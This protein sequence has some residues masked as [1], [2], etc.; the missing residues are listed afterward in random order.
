MRARFGS[1]G[2]AP[3]IGND[4]MKLNLALTQ[5]YF[6]C[7]RSSLT[8]EEAPV[9]S[10][11]AGLKQRVSL[12]RLRHQADTMG[13]AWDSRAPW[14]MK[15]KAHLLQLLTKDGI[16]GATAVSYG[17][18]A[19][20]IPN[21]PSDW[22]PFDAFLSNPSQTGGM[23]F[24]MKDHER[25]YLDAYK[26]HSIIH[27]DRAS[28]IEA[29][30]DDFAMQVDAANGDH[31]NAKKTEITKTP[32]NQTYES[33]HAWDILYKTVSI[34]KEAGN[35]A[36]RGSQPFLAARRYD[37]AINYCSIAYLE[38]QVGNVDFLAEHQVAISD[39]DGYECRWNPLLKLLIQIRLNLSM[40]F[41]K[42]EMKDVK[43]AKNQANFSLRE[44]KP[45][46]TKKGVVLT[47]KKLDK[48]RT[49]EPHTTYTESK[50]LQSKA[51]FRLGSAQML[52]G[53]FDDAI[54]CFE[55]SVKSTKAMGD[56][57]DKVVLRKLSEAK[58]GC[59][60]KKERQK[61]KFKLMFGS[62][63]NENKDTSG[64]CENGS[65]AAAS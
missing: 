45:F 36:L 38:F 43:S 12:I 47:G 9:K 7:A 19:D 59:H 41:L 16:G 10:G 55:Q 42:D 31:E 39:N 63:I 27:V 23:V 33:T 24:N 48:E 56:K 21:N 17:S 29:D 26:D 37:K 57:P 5:N 13:L 52:M 58:K 40:C 18:L 60:Q 1:M 32:N 8:G 25:F 50:A 35:D 30:S 20:L 65:E 54:K 44:L 14:I 11:L 46:A 3:F 53:D 15:P 62:S 64:D 6:T 61:R 22:I 34:L 4:L 51:Y 49:D 28:F 2:V